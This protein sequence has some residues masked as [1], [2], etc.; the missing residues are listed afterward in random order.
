MNTIVFPDIANL[1]ELFTLTSIE[2][3]K[4]GGERLIAYTFDTVEHGFNKR[5]GKAW[6]KK[7]PCWLSGFVSL[8]DHR[9]G[10]KAYGNYFQLKPTPKLLNYISENM[11]L[12]DYD[13]INVELIVRADGSMLVTA[14]YGKILGSHWLALLPAERLNECMVLDKSA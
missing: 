6:Q 2:L 11:L 12:I 1:S 3:P 9:E 10:A 8:R 4:P 7:A 14:H 5:T 13:T